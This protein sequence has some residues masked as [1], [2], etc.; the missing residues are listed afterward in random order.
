MATLGLIHDLQV[1]SECAVHHP[2]ISHV[3]FTP[4][5]GDAPLENI[6]IWGACLEGF[7]L[8]LPPDVVVEGV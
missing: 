6:Q 7:Q 2:D 5:C 1:I 8:N 4:L 3:E